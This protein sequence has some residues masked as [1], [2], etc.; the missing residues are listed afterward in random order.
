VVFCVKELVMMWL[1]MSGD[2]IVNVSRSEGI[3]RAKNYPAYFL[4][5][6][7]PKAYPP[8]SKNL[9]TD[10]FQI[11]FKTPTHLPLVTLPI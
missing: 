11:H 7:N 6:A 10:S 5:L 1:L 9:T 8:S 4:L 2:L 3:I